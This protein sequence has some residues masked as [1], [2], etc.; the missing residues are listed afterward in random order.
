MAQLGWALVDLPMKLAGF[1]DYYYR[2]AKGDGLPIEEIVFWHKGRTWAMEDRERMRRFH[3]R[4]IA[5]HLDAFV[6]S[7]LYVDLSSYEAERVMQ[8]HAQ[9][10]VN[11]EQA[12]EV[13]EALPNTVK[14]FILE[15]KGANYAN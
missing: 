3:L 1:T 8:L 2:I 5:L 10:A 4:D 13:W 6:K 14:Q 11:Q 12:L 7:Q 15:N 9:L